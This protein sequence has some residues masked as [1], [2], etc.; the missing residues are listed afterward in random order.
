MDIDPDGTGARTDGGGERRVLY[1]D[2]DALIRGGVGNRLEERLGDGIVLRA[3]T[4]DDGLEAAETG[5]WSCLVLGGDLDPAMLNALSATIDC[6][7]VL[8]TSADPATVPDDV[9][10]G[11][12]TLVERG[13]GSQSLSFLA[14]KVQTILARSTDAAEDVL[15]DALSAVEQ[16]AEDATA[17]F[18]VDADG[19]VV[20]S[21]QDFEAT[22]PV[23]SI[24]TAIPR[25]DDFY[26]RLEAILPEVPAE[27]RLV[28]VDGGTDEDERSFVVP[29]TGRS[30][31]Y[32]HDRDDLSAVG[33]GLTLERFEDVT[34]RV[35]EEARRRLLEL[36]VEQ[37]QDGLYSLD[38][39][40]VIDFCN[41]SFATTLGYDREELIGEHAA[42]AL[43]PGELEAGQAT[44][45][46]LLDNP[47]R[48]SVEVDMRFLTRSGEEREM[49]VHY[50]LL[51]TEDDTYG[52]LMGVVRDVPERR[53][54][55]RRIEA[56]RD[57]LSTLDRTNVLVQKIIGAL[58]D[59]ASREEIQQMVC[60]R[61]T[62]SDRY[63]LA[64]IGERQGASKMMV[65]LASAGEA[66]GYLDNLDVRIDESQTG[67]GPGGRAYRTGNVQVINEVRSDDQVA[68]W[69]DRALS[70]GLE[71]MAAIPVC[72]G[73]TTHG[74][75]G[76]Y[77]T[78]PNAFSDRITESFTVLG[79][80]VGLAL[81]AIQNKRLLQRDATVVLEFQ[82]LSEDACLVW[83]ANACDCTLE[84]AGA[85]ETSD[86]VIQ[87]LHVDGTEPECVVEAVR[88]GETDSEAYVTRTQ[89]QIVEIHGS[90]SLSVQLSEAG[91]R[92]RT[93]VAHPDRVRIVV[94]ASANADVRAI[95]D[96][97]ERANPDTELTSKRE[98]NQSLHDDTSPSPLS[99]LTDR[100]RAV[101]RAAYL[102][103][104]YDWPRESTAEEVA[105]SLD[106]ASPTLHQHLR[107]A[108]GNLLDALFDQ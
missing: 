52:G 90:S 34:E 91:G 98:S 13:N 84:T 40:G 77:A 5:Q 96:V 72:H 29:T 31:F 27:T 16:Q 51:P 18:V 26:E 101:L 9:L 102:A 23:D 97:V 92:L 50:T 43:A 54:R 93:A 55:E 87:Y 19:Q 32:V 68:P 11:I 94:E 58:G 65:P 2:A 30:R 89:D 42:V 44:V 37:S 8:F 88:D 59:A 78:E 24:D 103:G 33:P 46:H 4:S 85:V 6:P 83:L 41:E 25:S 21:N 12:D 53:G 36:L 107:R 1:V 99:S 47:D 64:W 7:T 45:Q 106:I 86:G 75:L 22:F 66:V 61:L 108:E 71:S 105:E 100:Q 73:E 62:E 3:T 80:T 38:H 79:E 35:R 17:R 95:R 69:R 15:T 10:D 104:Y 67:N 20:W 39:N 28:E 70:A 48:D 82:S 60:D 76:V 81:T 49:S 74:I 56:Q 57:E 63:A 14:E